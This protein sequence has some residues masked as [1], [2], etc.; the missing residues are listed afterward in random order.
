MFQGVP[1][2]GASPSGLLAPLPRSLAARHGRALMGGGS[3][4][5]FPP[6]SAAR[7]RRA[8][9]FGGSP[10]LHL[11]ICRVPLLVRAPGGFV[12]P[13][14]PLCVTASYGPMA[15]FG[16]RRPRSD[17]ASHRRSRSRA[18][19]VFWQVPRAVGSLLRLRL[20]PMSVFGRLRPR[21]DWASH[22]CS[23]SRAG[24]VCW[25]VHCAAGSLLRLRLR[26][27][28]LSPRRASSRR[29]V[30]A[31]GWA[32]PGGSGVGCVFIPSPLPSSPPPRRD[33]D[34]GGAPRVLTPSGPHPL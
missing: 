28:V 21:T 19:E 23:R 25:R 4:S 7:V 1:L 12:L 29:A 11:P 3:P 15:V 24:E 32:L 5:P 10:I 9:P 34:S 31:I 13:L 22:R 16:R 14:L 8:G 30:S 27:R 6:S 17:W 33:W 20:G 26:L 2:A 18:G